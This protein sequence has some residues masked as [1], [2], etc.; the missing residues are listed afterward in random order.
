M[1]LTFKVYERAE[2]TLTEL[3]TVTSLI[4]KGKIKF[5]PGTI[6][7]FNAG[8][9]KSYCMILINAKGESTTVP[10]SKGLSRKVAAAFENNVAKKDILAVIAKL[11]VYDTE[12]GGIIG[13]PAGEMSEE[14]E[15]AVAEVSKSKVTYESLSSI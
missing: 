7:K 3:G 4:P 13:R 14:F 6:D 2:S 5:C 9:I 8:E 15:L 1:A 12:E 10:L 11:P